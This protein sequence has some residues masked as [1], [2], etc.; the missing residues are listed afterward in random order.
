MKLKKIVKVSSPGPIRAGKCSLAKI[1]PLWLLLVLPG[2]GRAEAADIDLE[3]GA[4][5]YRVELASTPEQRRQGLMF[6]SDLAPDRGMLLVYPAAGD[7]SVWMKN[8][9]I[10]LRVFWIDADY[11][12]VHRQRLEPCTES[13]CPVFAAPGKSRFILE[14]GDR[15]HAI[16][17]GDR[18][19][20]LDGL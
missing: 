14:L 1:V 17:L 2:F 18:V 11:R 8:M 12:V 5:R 20:G 13:P 7:H 3:I 10:P 9:K 4:Q 16:K 15:E 19:S 6:R